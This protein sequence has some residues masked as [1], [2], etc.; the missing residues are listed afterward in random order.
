MKTYL[1]LAV[2]VNIALILATKLIGAFVLLA[3]S[4]ALLYFELAESEIIIWWSGLLALMVIIFIAGYWVFKLTYE[5]TI[6]KEKITLGKAIIYSSILF[7]IINVLFIFF[8]E[9]T[10]LIYTGVGILFVSL[11]FYLAGKSVEKII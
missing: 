2:R 1:N 11:P 4:R 6:K 9:E 3:V 8:A 7:F 10:D 5:N